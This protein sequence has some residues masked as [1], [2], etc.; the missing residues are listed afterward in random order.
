MRSR[1][2]GAIARIARASLAAVSIVASLVATA[3]AQSAS[4][5]RAARQRADV[6]A[7][8]AA[9]SAV[10]AD[11]DLGGVHTTRYHGTIDLKKVALRA[12]HGQLGDRETVRG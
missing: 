1:T 3:H 6:A 4:A 12:A 5:P 10:R 8:E 2:D 11:T 9:A 7:V